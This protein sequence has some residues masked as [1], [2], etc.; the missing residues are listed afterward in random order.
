M[1]RAL[2]RAAGLGFFGKNTML[3]RPGT[4]SYFVL[5][6]VLTDLDLGAD[7]PRA[8]SCGTCS[9]CLPACPTGAIVAP[10]V[11]DARLCI[12][13]LTIEQ[14]GPIPEAL[15]PAVGSMVFG[16]DLCQEVCPW[17]RFA[18]PASAADLRPRE[19]ALAPDL[20]GLAAMGE[21]DWKAAFRGSAVLRAGF[22]GFRRNV[23][24]ALGNS[25]RPE[26]LP[27]LRALVDAGDPLV[28]EHARW[29]I[30]RLDFHNN[31]SKLTRCHE[32]A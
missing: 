27:A 30:D 19:V 9:R 25:G 8:G 15:R 28:A 18:R 24:V 26:A 31:R 32:S 14:D 10:F 21:E 1:D 17:N 11:L 2:A 20:L 23:A 3:I 7:A 5:G 29:G 4:G 12:S 13:Y 22:R 16:C 6:E